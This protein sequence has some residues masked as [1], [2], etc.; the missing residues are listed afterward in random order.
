MFQD[1]QS[2]TFLEPFHILYNLNNLDVK[3]KSEKSIKMMAGKKQ[4]DSHVIVIIINFIKSLCDLLQLSKFPFKRYT[5]F[6]GKNMKSLF[7]LLLK[8]L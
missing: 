6:T 4:E 5:V 7:S 3:Y 2:V 1:E 8:I